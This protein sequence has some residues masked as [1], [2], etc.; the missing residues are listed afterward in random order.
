MADDYNEVV[1]GWGYNCPELCADKVNQLFKNDKTIKILDIGC[2]DG[3]VGEALVKR[4]FKNMTGLDIS[5][6]MVKLAKEK[7]I[8]DRVLQADLMKPL[9]LPFSSYDAIT[10]VGVT[11]Y[12]EP[13]VIVEWCKVVKPGAYIV[14]TVKSGVLQKWKRGQ[15]DMVKR[16]LWKFVFESEPLFYLPTLRDPNQERVFIFVYQKL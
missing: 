14:F 3:L 8:Y 15:D 1:R 16:K 13:Y 11:T 7:N 2:G 6:K 9:P 10:C 12:I 4:G 5:G